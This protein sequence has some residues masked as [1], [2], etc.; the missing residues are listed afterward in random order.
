MVHEVENTLIGIAIGGA[1]ALTS[2]SGEQAHIADAVTSKDSLLFMT[3]HGVSNLISDSGYISYRIVS[4]EWLIYNPSGN[5][6]GRWEFNKGFFMQK[7]D[8]GYIQSDTA[9]CHNNRLWELRGRVVIR[10]RQG[11]VFRSEEFFWDMEEHEVYSN[12]YV[13]ITEPQRNIN[14]YNFRSNEDM[15]R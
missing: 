2:C 8:N 14:G 7:F 5:A 11:T 1:L 6:E 3:A 15:T 4:E 12:L 9:Y 10:N 13:S